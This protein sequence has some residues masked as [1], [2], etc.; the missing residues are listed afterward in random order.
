MGGAGADSTSELQYDTQTTAGAS[1]SFDSTMSANSYG[2]NVIIA[3]A[4]AADAGG[5]T[6]TGTVTSAA[7]ALAAPSTAAVGATS[8][9]TFTGDVTSAAEAL[10]APSTAA[11]GTFTPTAPGTITS[12]APALA[13]PVT[14]AVGTVSNPA[15]A[16]TITSTAPALADPTTAATG[17]VAPPVYVGDITTTPDVLAAPT[18]AAAGA[19]TVPVYTGTITTSVDPLAAPTTSLS[20][21]AARDITIVWLPARRDVRFAAA[22]RA[23]R[24]GDTYGPG[25]AD[26]YPAAVPV[27]ARFAGALRTPRF[28][29]ATR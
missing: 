20:D 28:E 25:Y 24:G 5:D 12:T 11:T 8:V 3:I 4:P 15:A 14:A 17:T 26:G 29:E 1:G 27:D 23:V 10:A 22:T 13:G 7:D 6:F 9:P 18:T 21:Q 2:P 16:G 19:V